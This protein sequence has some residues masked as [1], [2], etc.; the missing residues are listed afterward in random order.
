MSRFAPPKEL[1]DAA[2]CARV[3][4]YHS[5]RAFRYAVGRGEY[6]KPVAHECHRDLWDAGQVRRQWLLLREAE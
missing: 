1:W 5:A 4:G 2:K 6:P 3:L